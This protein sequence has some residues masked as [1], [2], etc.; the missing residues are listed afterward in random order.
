MMFLLMDLMS[1]NLV[2]SK[3]PF[4][5]T[6]CL[7]HLVNI[8]KK[9][10]Q[11]KIKRNDPTGTTIGVDFPLG[12]GLYITNECYREI[13]QPECSKLFDQSKFT[14]QQSCGDVN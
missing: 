6:I 11:T 12:I 3:F 1:L 4:W 9:I 14:K 8:D 2:M 5:T 10:N 13:N 7:F